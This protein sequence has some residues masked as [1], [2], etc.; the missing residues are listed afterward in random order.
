M[1]K[2]VLTFFVF[3]ILVSAVVAQD[4][5]CEKTLDGLTCRYTDSESCD[6][7]YLSTFALCEQTSFCDVGTCI[8]SE[9]GQCFPNTPRAVCEEQGYTWHEG[10]MDSLAQCQQGCCT[11]GDQAFFVTEV[12]CKSVATE[13]GAKFIFDD[14]IETEV[15]CVDSVRS[16]E[17]GCC[18]DSG[19]YT[20]TTRSS[21]G[22]AGLEVANEGEDG[23]YS[24][25]LCSNDLLSSGCAKQT[26]TECYD[27][28]VYW[29]D[30][31]GNRENVWSSDEAKSYN[32]GFYLEPDNI[33]IAES[34]DPDCGNCDYTQGMICSEDENNIAK[35]S[36][37]YCEDINCEETYNDDYSFSSG[38]DKKNGE[39]WCIYDSLPGAARDLV[40]SR[41]YRH[42][43]INGE[44][45]VDPCQDYREE[46]CIQGTLD[47]GILSTFDAL[48]LDA[49]SDYVEA[50]CRDNRWEE[51]SSCNDLIQEYDLETKKGTS[52][53][54][55]YY[56]AAYTCCVNDAVRDCF[57]LQDGT[58]IEDAD[59]YD[60]FGGAYE[61]SEWFSTKEFDT[62]AGLCVPNV[63]PG[64]QFWGDTEESTADS[65]A[66]SQ[67]SLAS[68]QCYAKWQIGGFAKI[69][70]PNNPDSWELVDEDPA[71]CMSRS[72]LVDQNTMCKAMGDCGAYY[73]ILGTP[74][75]DGFT[76]SMFGDQNQLFEFNDLTAEDLDDWDVLIS[77]PSP[78]EDNPMM[79]QI[80]KDPFTWIAA[81]SIL[82]GGVTSGSACFKEAKD[83]NSGKPMSAFGSCF[84]GTVA[85]TSII[86]LGQSVFS[87]IQ[88]N[89][90]ISA[91][92][93]LL[94]TQNAQQNQIEAKKGTGKTLSGIG[95]VI[96][97]GLLVKYGLQDTME[98]T[99]DVE[100]L[101]WVPPQTNDC[102]ECNDEMKPC[103]E[104]K[105][106]SLGASCDLINEGTDEEKCVSLHPND[107]VSPEISPLDEVFV[108]FTYTERT[109]EGNK[110]IDINEEIP[111][112]K[113]IEIGI[114]TNE[115]AQCKF[116]ETPATEF[117]SM[118]R[119]FGESLYLYEHKATLS[120]PS[121]LTEDEYIELTGGQHIL[122]VRCQDAN[123][124]VNN[125]DYFIRF[126]I[127]T[128]PDLTPP[129]IKFTSLG[130]QQYIAEDVNELPYS[131][132]M[133]EP[134]ECRWS[135]L[136][137]DYEL[138]SNQ[139]VCSS[140][141]FSTS[142]IYHGT[143]LCSSTLTNVSSL[144]VNNYYFRCK[145][146]P[147]NE[148]VDSNVNKE[149][150]LF[151]TKA[152]EAL[153]MDEVGPTGTQY[154]SSVSLT[155]ETSE[156]A[157]NGKAICGYADLED[158]PVTEMIAF[159]NTN[160]SKHSQPL[161]LPL[162]S[163]TY[164]I[165]CV[166]SAGNTVYNETTF[167]VQVDEQAPSLVQIYADTVFQVLH[168]DFNEASTCEYNDADFNYGEGS[169]M[170]GTNVTAHEAS[171][172][173]QI[174]YVRC[175]DLYNNEGLYKV[176]L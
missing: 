76:S 6:A 41:H 81:G 109:E 175:I 36:E 70:T 149:S 27:G 104:Y 8:S 13:Y 176:Y 129:E 3:L 170:T 132:Y 59:Y 16:K 54:A 146:Q 100:C 131:L 171:L 119:Y 156:G 158:V 35:E 91:A 174:Y 15:A 108:E 98:A 102:E 96:A 110:G 90:P 117:E 66:T 95:W 72:W 19:S 130:E 153:V 46:I 154:S 124:N 60:G 148:I 9:A 166:D 86:S 62:P 5:C 30:S 116:S 84:M 42:L 28:K 99:F 161:Q 107:V 77:K 94:G 21:C 87:M 75:T 4:A 140:S 113:E 165:G 105:C 133:S 43:C 106:H 121:E 71:G 50:A 160:S 33:C 151:T 55:A 150:F 172:T 144:D 126:T 57:W 1:R 32:N 24:G 25:M 45:V 83:E 115:P 80:L 61:L 26:S 10:S 34:N 167:D 38:G 47:S 164:Y 48:N 82:A 85:P 118:T 51:C 123:G 159:V 65:S 157:E 169:P 39:S 127:D 163:Y 122:Y 49:G 103:S 114:E 92:S 89:N 18:V 168:L 2:L 101:P 97:I 20:F 37:F 137:T 145:D 143:Y 112:F 53:Y 78:E 135:N 63:P 134:S 88:G 73:N 139:L 23:F 120:L 56:K 17:I 44:E 29:F 52:D 74:S 125:R 31:C 12:Q 138:M 58:S 162:G 11:I 152:T 111:P 79:D 173:Q 64:L 68:T 93:G 67:C 142:S 128:S 22:S 147:G 69:F 7:N 141:A 40:G 155:A 136:D 14:T